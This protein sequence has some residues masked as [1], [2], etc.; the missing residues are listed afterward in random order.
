MM[1]IRAGTERD[2]PELTALYNH[3]AVGTHITFDTEPQDVEERRGWLANYATTGRHRLLVAQA[4][5]RI[6]GYAT[7]S[8]FR[9]KPGYDTSVETTVYVHPDSTG[10]GIGRALYDALFAALAD[11]DVHRAY[12]GIALPNDASVALHVSHGFR[13]I[14]TFTE[15]GHKLGRWWDVAW[16]ERP[17]K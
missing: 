4:S 9:V 16:Y 15:V 17:V 11:E 1:Q 10:G 7:S 13:H 3:Y 14:G 8:R 12:A 6:V 5:G 2:L